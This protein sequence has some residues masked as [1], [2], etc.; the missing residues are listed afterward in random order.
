MF[1]RYKNDR[2][3]VVDDEEFCHTM[4]KIMLYKVG[5]DVD[6]RVDICITGLEALETIK[7]SHD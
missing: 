7:K 1:N 4:M 6:H 5:I 2:I 3:L